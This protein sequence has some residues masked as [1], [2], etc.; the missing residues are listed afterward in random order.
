MSLM[1]ET[2]TTG[3]RG[4]LGVGE[5]FLEGGL[6]DGNLGRG[7]GSRKA[8]EAMSH[9]TKSGGHWGMRE[10]LRIDLK[11]LNSTF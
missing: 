1:T 7:K 4:R 3:S 6:K 2:I 10:R 11:L 9:S 8:R 5:G